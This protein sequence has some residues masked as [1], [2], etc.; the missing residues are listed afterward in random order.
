MLLSPSMQH[1]PHA[2][3]TIH[4]A[5]TS[6]CCHHPCDIHLTLLLLSIQY[7]P[8]HHHHYLSLNHEGRWGIADDFSTSFLHFSL[9]STA[10]WDL[11]NTR[12]VHSLMLSSHFFLCLPCHLSPFTVPCNM[13]LARPDEGKH[14]HT[15]AVC[16]SLR[17]SRGLYV[18][19]LPNGSWHG[20]LPW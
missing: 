5:S 10:L 19:Q 1:S 18:V 11:L 20:L 13:V 14:G 2:A 9:F 3:V 17:L 8:H 4:S 15:T 16:I 7:S 12:P 6:H